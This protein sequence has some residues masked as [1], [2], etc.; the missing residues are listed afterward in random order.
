MTTFECRLDSTDDLDFESCTSPHPLT[1]P[2]RRRIA[3]FRGPRRRSAPGAGDSPATRSFT[4][5]TIA[6]ETAIDSGPTG[7]TADNRPTFTFSATDAS[8]TTFRCRIDDAGFGPC[9]GPGDSH[10]PAGSLPDGSH[11][12]EVKAVDAASNAEETPAI[13]NFTVD[14]VAPATT[15]DSGPVGPTSDA[16]P[17]FTF[18]APDESPTMF[19][20]RVGGGDFGPCSGPGQTH[21]TAALADGSYAFQVRAT[22]GAGNSKVATWLFKIDTSGPPDTTPPDTTFTKKPKNRIKTKKKKA[23]V[24]VAFSSEPGA[25]FRCKLDKAKYEPCTSP[26]SVKARSKPGKGK[27]HA[28]SV[29]AIDSAGNV[30]E[31]IVVGFRVVRKLR[32]KES[33]AERT[34]VTALQRHGFAKRVVK[35]VHADCSRR[36]YSAFS[37]KFSGS[38]PG[39]RLKGRGEVELRAHLSYRFRVKAQ[40]VRL[41]LTDRNE[42]G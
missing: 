3:F 31:P 16:T 23:G 21:T 10:T 25:A 13:R 12:F 1:P 41:T 17:T 28:I 39:Y 18:S 42:S 26:Y 33:V 8:S 27:K 9:S 30:G 22:D 38:F 35:A 24:E 36:A 7:R 5:D 15:V 11:T 4:V 20:C 6:P 19:Q 40:G 2:P 32:L 29:R 14:T 34:V 37:C